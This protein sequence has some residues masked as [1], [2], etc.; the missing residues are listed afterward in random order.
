MTKNLNSDMSY[1]FMSSLARLMML[2][3]SILSSSNNATSSWSYRQRDSN[4]ICFVPCDLS[5]G[6]LLGWS[7]FLKFCLDLR[8]ILCHTSEVPPGHC[9]PFLRTILSDFYCVTFKLNEVRTQQN[10]EYRVYQFTSLCS[11]HIYQSN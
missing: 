8:K 11:N 5:S 4:Q 3:S 9:M 7:L 2:L 6:C 1:V 10:V